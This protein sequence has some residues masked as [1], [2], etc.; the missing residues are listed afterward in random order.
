[1]CIRDRA[2]GA[3]D[4]LTRCLAVEWAPHGILVNS[5]APGYVDTLMS[6]VDGVNEL[7][8]PDFQEFYVRRR[9]IPLARAAQPQEIAAAVLFFCLPETSFTTGQTLLVDGAHDSYLPEF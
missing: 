4:Q 8:T 3:V 1:M 6:V 2:K 5:V 7:D 9:K